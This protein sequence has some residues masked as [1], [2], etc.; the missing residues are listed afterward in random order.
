MTVI[1]MIREEL[2][3]LLVLIELA[4]GRTWADDVAAF[5][6]SVWDNLYLDLRERQSR[7]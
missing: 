6:G 1:T 5:D 7:R 2:S 3:R 4:D